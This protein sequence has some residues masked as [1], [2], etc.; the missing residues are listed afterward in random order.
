MLETL[1][2]GLMGGVFRLV[3]EFLKWLDRA[4]ERSHELAMQ[5]KALAFEQ[6]R[7][8][9][10]MTEIGA[11]S[12]AAWD[13]GALETLKAS[14]D[15]QGRPSGIRWVDALSL[16]VRPVITYWFM[17]LYC[18]VKIAGFITA[19]RGGVEWLAAIPLM[20]GTDDMAVWAGLLN[21]WFLGRVFEKAGR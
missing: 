12:Q 14:I 9:N 8:A 21:F 1:L 7:G 17:L 16:T 13:M 15:A 18:A 11:A 3:P 19:I 5:D 2:G 10:R 20:W 6:L 4:S